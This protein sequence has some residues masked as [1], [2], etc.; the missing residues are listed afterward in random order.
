MELPCAKMYCCD[1][2]ISTNNNNCGL[3]VTVMCSDYNFI[4][5]TQRDNKLPHSTAH[6][7]MGVKLLYTSARFTTMP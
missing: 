2:N 7:S 1:K 4:Y 6:T 3:F 5:P